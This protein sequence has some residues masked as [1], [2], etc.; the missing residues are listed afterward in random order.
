MRVQGR[1]V[2]ACL[3][4]LAMPALGSDD[5]PRDRDSRQRGARQVSFGDLC[6]APFK[7][8]ICSTGSEV[9]SDIDSLGRTRRLYTRN[10]VTV[11]QPGRAREEERW[12]LDAKEVVVASA[13]DFDTKGRA[14]RWTEQLFLMDE[15][16]TEE[17]RYTSG[18]VV[19]LSDFNL[20]GVASETTTYNY[21]L[22]E[23]GE[24]MFLSGTKV[25]LDFD[26]LG[27]VVQSVERRFRIEGGSDPSNF[28]FRYHQQLESLY[29]EFDAQGNAGYVQTTHY[30]IDEDPGDRTR[31][32]LVLVSAKVVYNSHFDSEGN[33]RR[34][35]T[36]HYEVPAPPGERVFTDGESANYTYDPRNNLV[37]SST[38]RYFAILTAEETGE[39]E[40]KY[41]NGVV[42]RNLVHD[43]SG[44]VRL[45]YSL[46]FEIAPGTDGQHEADRTYTTAVVIKNREVDLDGRVTDQLSLSVPLSEGAEGWLERTRCPLQRKLSTRTRSRSGGSTS[47]NSTQSSSGETSRLLSILAPS[48]RMRSLACPDSKSKK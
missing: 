12:Y 35:E 7:L 48:R 8:R 24:K 38:T 23:S 2:I 15:R 36:H 9:V 22:D 45:S 19:D 13:G 32:G 27:R 17:P 47:T 16:A 4:V 33:A 42:Q 3:V 6:E 37:S 14:V 30:E 43:L 28:R 29:A 31:E 41:T 1:W 25:R 5:A 44:N 10:F 11:Q 40:R 21:R 34:V 18:R 46:H 20:Q 39:I 26:D